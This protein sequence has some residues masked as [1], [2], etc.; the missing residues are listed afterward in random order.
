MQESLV[1]A[2]AGRGLC[3]AEVPRGAGLAGVRAF[4]AGAS[5]GSP[6]PI[7][8]A[9]SVARSAGLS[10]QAYGMSVAATRHAVLLRIT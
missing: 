8:D 3:F 2:R 6:A 5:I 9:F 4:S 1:G 7:G 10:F